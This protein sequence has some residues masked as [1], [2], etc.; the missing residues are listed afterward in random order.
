MAA[1]VASVQKTGLNLPIIAYYVSRLAYCI[2]IVITE[3]NTA[4]DTAQLEYAKFALWWAASA[5]TSLLFF[6]RVRAVYR[7][8]R[9]VRALFIVLWV[10]ILVSPTAILY[11][12]YDPCE[13]GLANDCEVSRPLSLIANGTMCLNDTLVFV[14]VSWQMYSNSFARHRGGLSGRARF[15]RFLRGQGLYN[16]SKSVLQSGQLYYGVTIGFQLSASLTYTL[17]APYSLLVG[18]AYI[19]LASAM[20]TRVFRMVLLCSTVV[21]NPDTEMVASFLRSGSGRGNTTLGGVGIEGM[22]VLVDRE[23][24]GR[25]AALINRD[26]GKSE[27]IP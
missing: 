7:H 2:S 21:E 11:T 1:E 20:A 18:L 19:A 25:K 12:L 4:P 15:A 14:L 13:P 3:T 24:Q 17:G 27:A 10:L 26:T 22:M 23:G 8:N 9:A 6:F 16:I 5:A